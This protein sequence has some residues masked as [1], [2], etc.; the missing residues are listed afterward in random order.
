MA[1][2]KGKSKAPISRDSHSKLIEYISKILEKHRHFSNLRDKLEAIDKAYFMYQLAEADDVEGLRR[3][4]QESTQLEIPLAMSQ[5]DS[6]T[7]FL[8]DIFVSGHPMIGVLGSKGK[9]DIADKLEAL[10]NDHATRAEWVPN[11]IGNIFNN[12]KYNFAALEVEWSY[13]KGYQIEESTTLETEAPEL[14]ET[15]EGVNS[16]KNLDPYNVLWDHRFAP[17]EAIRKGDYSGY[18]EIISK[19]E[20]Q[21][22]ITKLAEKGNSFNGADALKSNSSGAISEHYI[23]R[24]EISNYACTDRAMAVNWEAYALG[25]SQDSSAKKEYKT[26]YLKHVLYL[27][28]VPEEFGISAT[29]PKQPQLW[30][31]VVINAK[32]IISMSKVN[33][34]DNRGGII[35]SAL[36]DDGYELQ[37][38]SIT[39]VTLPS[40]DAASDLL[41]VRVN[42]SRRALGDRLIYD[43]RYISKD[44]INSVNPAS[45][46]ALKKGLNED[47]RFSDVIYQVPFDASGTAGAIGDMQQVLQLAEMS[48][49]VN[50]NMQGMFRKG[51]RT[52]GEVQDV[53]GASSIRSMMLALNYEFRVMAH[54]KATIKLNTLLRATKQQILSPYRQKILDIDPAEF[55]ATVLEFKLADGLVNKSKLLP[56]EAFAS[57]IQFFMQSE[58]MNMEYDIPGM[59]IHLSSIQGVTGLSAFKREQAQL[60]P[61]QAQQAQ[62]QPQQPAQGGQPNGA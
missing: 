61:Q 1:E 27:R 18:A 28:I 4:K 41:N 19:W 30:K 12:V 6:V 24:P 36:K 38:P 48:H 21:E 46:L 56:P 31:V 53:M 54:F 47:M 13:I 25:K 39:E 3:I 43:E 10:F 5:V 7:A 20:L 57:I 60:P 35:I 50:S 45:K 16:A 42:A 17:N 29:K 40:Q 8:V 9:E 22:L 44:D 51:N 37:T 32:H 34:V 26:A 33:S 23:E 49:G 14:R 62:G 11:F 55:R 2:P 59:V 15:W 52:L 58:Q